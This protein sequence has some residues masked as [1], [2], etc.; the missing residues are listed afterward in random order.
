MTVTDP[1]VQDSVGTALHYLR[2]NWRAIAITSSIGAAATT[3]A[4]LAGGLAPTLPL[5]TVAAV[6]FLS[7]LIYAVFLGMA[8]RGGPPRFVWSEGVRLFAAMA[9][10]GFFLIVVAFVLTLAGLVVLLAG[11]YAPFVQEIE[12]VGGDQAA[13]GQILLRMWMQNPWPV[14]ILTLVYLGVWFYLTTRLYLAAPATLDRGRI[15]TFETWSWTK[16]AAVKVMGARAMLVGPAFVL[17]F[18]L[19]Y[20]LARAAGLDLFNANQAATA[21]PAA[22]LAF[23]IVSAFINFFVSDG[24]SAGLSTALYRDLGGKNAALPPR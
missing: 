19:T 2:S 14:L 11:P 22:A 4:Q 15:L 18:A 1:R 24:V 10:V 5:L 23:A 6:L 20:L 7:A 16:Q 8:L 3:M 21:Q 17:T 9:V 12:R 13:V